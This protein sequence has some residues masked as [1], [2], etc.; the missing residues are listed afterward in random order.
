[1]TEEAALAP[2]PQRDPVT[3]ELPI[4]P[5]EMSN[6]HAG[7]AP[8]AGTGMRDAFHGQ[9]GIR[10]IVDNMVDRATADPRISEI[11]VSHDLVR[12]RR[13]LFEQ[14]CYILNAGCDYSGRDM[15]SSHKDLGVQIDDLNVLVEN[16]QAAMAVE[17]VSFAAQNRLLSKLAP[18]NRDVVTR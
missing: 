3:G 10:R 1:M 14:F 4:D 15:A 16:L 18:M 9:D 2:E 8:F 12:L 17:R 6:A 7:A 11:F 5:Y 13:T